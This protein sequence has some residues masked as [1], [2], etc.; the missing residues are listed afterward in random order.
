M[1]AHFPDP[2]GRRLLQE[3]LSNLQK[4]PPEYSDAIS[5]EL[6]AERKRRDE[7]RKSLP[8]P[9]RAL[10]VRLEQQLRYLKQ[11]VFTSD[12]TGRPATSVYA[13]ADFFSIGMTRK[14]WFQRVDEIQE[15][16]PSFYMDPRF[17]AE[18]KSSNASTPTVDLTD[19][20]QVLRIL[21]PRKGPKEWGK[22]LKKEGFAP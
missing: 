22:F 4:L 3:I 1:N 19:A 13:L 20:E 10:A 21:A 18:K 7:T 14:K 12:A 8:T 6:E 5:A 16:V 17:R 9:E 15:E 2:G 11:P